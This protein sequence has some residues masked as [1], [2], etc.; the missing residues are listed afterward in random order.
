M[1]INADFN[2]RV[3]VYP[4]DVDWQPSPIAGVNRKMLDRIGEEKARATSIVKYDPGSHFSEHVHDGGE[5]I[6]VL[7]GVF[8]DESGDYP[9]GSYVRNPI[10]SI[11]KPY[12]DNGAVIF[13]KLHQFAED[14]LAR[15]CIDTNKAQFAPGLVEGLSVLPLHTHFGENVAL[16]KWEPNTT[17]K[18]H[19]HFGGEEILVL[20]GIFRDEHGE[21]PEG[22][23]L[24][25]PHGSSHLPFTLNEGALIYVKTG[26]LHPA[27]ENV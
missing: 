24:R 9:A 16:V 3:V 4:A 2:E 6:L 13:V 25:N 15:V 12:S 10:G 20:E 26:H 5:E 23:W 19:A 1:R 17:F 27:L 11:H 18:R 7:K 22:T 8:S 21:Y 14:D